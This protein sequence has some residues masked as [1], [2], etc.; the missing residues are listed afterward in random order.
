MPPAFRYPAYRAY[1]LGTLASVGGFQVLTFGQI[2]LTYE[3]T[4]SYVKLGFVAS[5]NAIPSIALNLFGGVFAD[6]LDKRKLIIVT[7]L[8]TASLIFLLGTLT[9]T[10]RIEVW[11]ILAIALVS[12]ATNAFDQPARQAL[13]PHLIDR[14]VMVSAV[15]L[16]SA[17][18]QGTRIVAPTVAGV[19]I[20]AIDT[21]AAFYLAGSGFVV[22]AMVMFW[23]HIPKI[24]RGSRG[25]AF[26]DMFDGLKFIGGNSVFWFLIG[27]T[28]F[29]SF[30]GMA[31][32]MM[33]PVF[34]VDILKVGAED[35]GLLMSVGGIG[36]LGVTIVLGTK[37]SFVRRGYLIIGG[38]VVF[39]LSVAAFALTAKY[40]HNYGLTMVFMVVM[41]ISSS[42]Y[43]ISIM[44]SLQILVPNHMRGR[45][46]GFYGMTWSIMPLG[47]LWAGILGDA[48]DSVPW[49]IAIGGLLVSGFAIGPAAVNKKLRNIGTLLQEAEQGPPAERVP[50]SRPAEAASAR[51]ASD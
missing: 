4:G 29:N 24:E 15:A 32:I 33:M 18:W 12:G 25:N 47:A 16:N 22:M 11:H 21:A 19:I 8:V 43:M 5:A 7:Q 46:M 38:A 1:W 30:F 42:T 50:P 48:L 26:Q 28:F 39:G 23:L 27:M 20:G 17:I 41:G 45:V 13:Y 31:Y 37:A 40:F 51:S 14:T 36:A 34:T 9:L 2:W 49:A 10:G 35:Q 6:R 3:L 44:S